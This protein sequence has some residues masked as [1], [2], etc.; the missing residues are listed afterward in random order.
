MLAH[1]A[2]LAQN[3]KKPANL[4]DCNISAIPFR[5]EATGVNQPHAARLYA[6]LM[7]TGGAAVA[8]TDSAALHSVEE[9]LNSGNEMQVTGYVAGV[10]ISNGQPCISFSEKQS[11]ITA[12]PWFRW[13]G[14]WMVYIRTGCQ[15][16]V[17]VFAPSEGKGVDE[18]PILG[19]GDI[20]ITLT[21]TTINNISLSITNPTQAAVCCPKFGQTEFSAYVTSRS[22]KGSILLPQD[23][24][25]AAGISMINR[26]LV[27]GPNDE[28]YGKPVGWKTIGELYMR[29]AEKSGEAPCDTCG[30]WRKKGKNRNFGVAIATGPVLLGWKPFE[31]IPWLSVRASLMA[32]YET[33][34][35]KN[36]NAGWKGFSIASKID[37][38][39]GRAYKPHLEL[40]IGEKWH[41]FPVEPKPG[42]GAFNTEFTATFVVPFGQSEEPP[43]FVKNAKNRSSKVAKNAPKKIWKGTKKAGKTTWKATKKGAK[44]TWKGARKLSKWTAKKFKK[45]FSKK[46][47]KEETSPVEKQGENK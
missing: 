31:S 23:W 27:L 37:L 43:R 5:N 36:E 10:S 8:T 13:D 33:P 9:A 14:T 32:R 29:V 18:T 22:L 17:L 39:I 47:K 21:S 46:N 6:L 15:N 25:P 7:N 24:E 26:K 4:P 16:P 38:L 20:N 35:R 45:T 42:P 34:I 2:G 19:R 3:F 1:V 40:G 28:V 44:A 11:T 41:P 30:I 12:V